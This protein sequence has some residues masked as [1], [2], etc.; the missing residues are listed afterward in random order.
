MFIIIEKLIE[1]LLKIKFMLHYSIHGFPVHEILHSEVVFFE[2]METQ[3]FCNI[4]KVALFSI[5]LF[6]L[7][8]SITPWFSN[9]ERGTTAN[10]YFLFL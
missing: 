6:S 3:H 9:M 5:T 10:F 1:K 2:V 7:L 4:W 8:P